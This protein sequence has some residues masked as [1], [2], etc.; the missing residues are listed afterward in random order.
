VQGLDYFFN[1]VTQATTW[2]K[3]DALKTQ[4][5]LASTGAWVWMP[6]EED[7][8]LPVKVMGEG[9]GQMQVQTEQGQ[10][11]TIP[12]QQLA[13]LKPSSLQRVVSDLTL[14]DEMSVP[15]ILHNL[16]KRFENKEIYTNIGTIL[17]SLNPYCNLGLYTPE[18]IH[19][20]QF[21]G[22]DEKPPHVFNIAFDANHG[23]TSFGMDQS[24]IISGESGAGKTE[25][26]KQC[27]SFIA[28]AAG[29]I[30]GVEKKILQANPILEGFGNAKTVRNDNSSRFGKYME[31]FINGHGQIS[32]SQTTNY[33]LEKIRVVRPG[34][35]ERN[36]H[37]FYQLTKAADAQ[38]R[39]QCSIGQPSDYLYLNQTGVID[40]PSID[41]G[42][43]YQEMQQALNDLGFRPDEQMN[44][45]CLISGILALG[46]IAIQPNGEGS[47]ADPA[48]ANVAAALLA[49]DPQTLL[50]ALTSRVLKIRGQ[51][52]TTVQQN[53]E[54]ASN[55]R[56]ALAKFIYGNMF[57][58]IV[59]KVNESMGSTGKSGLSIG[60]LDIFGFEIFE[61]NSFEQLCINL[62]NEMLQQHFNNHTFKKEEKI[63]Q[64]EG[65]TFRHV[66]FIDNQPVLS[67][68]IDKPYGLL[69]LCDEELVMPQGS[70]R[71]FLAKAM[72]RHEST[73]ILAPAQGNADFFTVRH[74]AGVVA[75]NSV[76]FLEKNKDTLT[77]DLLA[78]LAGSRNTLLNVLFPKNVQQSTAQRKSSLSKQFQKQLRDLMTVLNKTEPH[79]IRCI[80]PNAT[81]SAS[82]FTARMCLDQLTYAGVFE[83]V[84][85]RKQGYPFRLTHQKFAARYKCLLQNQNMNCLGVQGCQS[86][87][88]SMGFN[89]E[90]VK[91]GRTMMLYR[92]EEHK[93]MELQYSIKMV[94]VEMDKELNELINVN[95]ASM[96]PMAQEKYFER[97]SRA[98]QKANSFRLTSQTSE[99]ARQ[100]LDH[101]IE[102]R[103]DP[104]TRQ[105]LEAAIRSANQEQ[106]AAAVQQSDMHHYDAKICKE[107]K[108]MLQRV[109]RINEETNIAAST[110]EEK[111]VIAC[112]TAGDEIGASTQWLDYFRGLVNGPQEAFLDAQ[113]EAAKKAGNHDRAVRID[114]RRKDL[115]YEKSK[116]QY[117]IRQF[118][119]LKSPAA[120][121]KEK[122]MG[123]GKAAASFVTWQPKLIHSSITK[124]DVSDPKALKELNQK[125]KDAFKYVMKYMKQRD[126]KNVDNHGEIGRG[127]EAVT[128]ALENKE[129]RDELYMQLYKQ[130][131]NNPDRD[132]TRLGWDLLGLCLLT[133]PPSKKLENFM[134]VWMRESVQE[135][136]RLYRYKGWLRQRVYQGAVRQVPSIEQMKEAEKTLTS[137]SRGFSEPLPKGLPSWND[138]LTKYAAQEPVQNT[139]ARATP[140]AQAAPQQAAFQQSQSVAAAYTAP[141]AVA[142]A[143]VAPAAAPAAAAPAQSAWQAIVDPG[144]GETYYYNS[145]TGASSWEKPPELMYAQPAGGARGW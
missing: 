135:Q 142:A 55:A 115:L 77:E 141:M 108:R 58:W 138:L 87:T 68:L 117:D 22:L 71:K 122:F 120:W 60:I 119:N 24:I 79:Y 105:M 134:E 121:G 99:R 76:G 62:T 17:I 4:D 7:C 131:Q 109:T 114:I 98:V 130:I 66:D 8:F 64:D 10:Q 12:S 133:F 16:K 63:Y 11:Y 30:G 44:M 83:A 56:H 129:I 84:A 40:V 88:Q 111:H 23:V 53:A 35:T 103:M 27:L 9:G 36:F 51:A 86:I 14:L 13:S 82:T 90:N 21:R 39:G 5:E 137:R 127:R 95:T 145:Q 93:Q 112:V 74:Y 75:Y 125:A 26:T 126:C 1:V 110:I 143:P 72:G 52:D 124:M 144:S 136:N 59:K 42:R 65:V 47:H 2:D 29:S 19:D 104:Q 70:D 89:Q 101:Y 132:A 123:G 43:D 46:N 139:F 106:L 113:F 33:L 100:L 85:I 18:V 38:L 96:Q 20:Y 37:I 57:N 78:V 92:A 61:E 73:G 49:V 31:V 69:C 67:M 118:P 80:K 128:F 34:P 50:N 102:S 3:P 6:V 81:K 97:L 94:A 54:A 116:G 107:A 91:V 15:L 25:A 48:W 28:A 32:G 45:W 41:D 140:A